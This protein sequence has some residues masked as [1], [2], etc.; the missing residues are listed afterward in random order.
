MIKEIFEVLDLFEEQKW[1][2]AISLATK[3]VQSNSALY[4]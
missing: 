4:G 1:D 2:E 3:I